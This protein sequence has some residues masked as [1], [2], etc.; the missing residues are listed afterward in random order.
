MPW[1]LCTILSYHTQ[2]IYSYAVIVSCTEVSAPSVLSFYMF[3]VTDVKD[4]KG[5]SSCPLAN[6]YK[7]VDSIFNPELL[8]GEYEICVSVIRRPN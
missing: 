8:S 2:L 3:S 6:G 7:F 4:D 1:K 5:M